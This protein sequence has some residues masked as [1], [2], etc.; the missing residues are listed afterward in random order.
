MWKS[1]GRKKKKK[2]K[3]TYAGLTEKTRLVTTD[4]L[5][6]YTI[7]VSAR[8]RSSAVMCKAN[9]LFCTFEPRLEYHNT[10]R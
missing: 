4:S 9:V 8:K 10:G 3:I 5:T 2:K 6:G 7:V 1:V